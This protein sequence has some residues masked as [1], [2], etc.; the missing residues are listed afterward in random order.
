MGSLGCLIVPINDY[1]SIA[2]SEFIGCSVRGADVKGGFQVKC[3]CCESRVMPTLSG[4]A[5]GRKLFRCSRCGYDQHKNL[6]GIGQYPATPKSQYELAIP[7]V[8]SPA[9]FNLEAHWAASGVGPPPFNPMNWSPELVTEM[10]FLEGGA[11]ADPRLTSDIA[12]GLED[13]TGT[14]WTGTHWAPVGQQRRDAT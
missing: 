10:L 4:E 9:K 5:G 7:E 1:I 11:T 13:A 8:T 2:P 6:F 12:E 14:E 3:A